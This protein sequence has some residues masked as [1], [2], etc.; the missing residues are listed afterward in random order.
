MDFILIAFLTLLNGIFAMSEMALSASRKAR[1]TALAESGDKGAQGA[2]SLLDNP[3]QFLSSV[4]VGITSIGML[5]GIIG[6][7]AF[8]SGLSAWIQTFGAS[9]R[10]ADI[11]ATALV[12]TIITYITIVF[13]ELVPKRIGQLYPETVARL[14]SRPMMWVATAA[15]PFV[16]LLSFSTHSVL[17]L[18]R[19]DTAGDRTVTDEEIAASLEEGVDAGLIEEHEHQ[20]VQNVFLL[21]DRLLTSLML[22]R[23]DIEW[24]DAGDTVAQAIVKAGATGH[25]WYPVCRGSLDDVVGVVNVA[26]LLALRGQIQPVG[27]ETGTGTTPTLADRIDTYAIPAMF[28]PETLTGMELLEQFRTQST[29]MVFVVDE[30]G[31]VQGLMTPMD[32]LEAITGELQPGAQVDAWATRR[33]DGSWLI[34]GVMPVSELKA[35]LDIRELPDEDRGRYN[36]VAGLLQSV[37]G[38]LLGTGDLVDAAGWRFEVLDLDGK[39]IDKVLVS[40]IAGQP[41]EPA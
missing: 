29:R 8:S 32:M 14:V 33:A 6:E 9:P 40:Q 34:D 26:K 15:K 21:D 41:A 17:K 31:V 10:A 13:G 30:Y 27:E 23:S 11:T 1:L 20:M 22:P 3:T 24:L 38:R 25:S 36:T 39:R 28:V 19:V 35:R 5:N 4:Q 7:A 37:S 2:L 12:V 16:R 18:L